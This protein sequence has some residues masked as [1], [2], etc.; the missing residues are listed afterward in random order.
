MI[1]YVFRKRNIFFFWMMLLA[2]AVVVES[3][4]DSDQEK[5]DDLIAQATFGDKIED[6]MSHQVYYNIRDKMIWLWSTS[7]HDHL[8][9]MS[10]SGS[11]FV[12]PSD[13]ERKWSLIMSDHGG[14]ATKIDH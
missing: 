7:I 6:R 12:D 8:P 4:E 11:Y 9:I 13:H 14:L 2:S 10:D 1:V 3:L 5:N